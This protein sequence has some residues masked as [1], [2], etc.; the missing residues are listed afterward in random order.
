MDMERLKNL[1]KKTQERTDADPKEL[2]Q[3]SPERIASDMLFK[4]ALESICTTLMPRAE[5]L[6]EGTGRTTISCLISI[7]RKEIV[8][9]VTPGVGGHTTI[10]DNRERKW[11]VKIWF[12]DVTNGEGA[13]ELIAENDEEI[14]Y[15]LPAI[16]TAICEYA[17]DMHEEDGHDTSKL[18]EFS[19][20]AMAKR[21]GGMH[22]A[23]SKGGGE[24]TL[25][26]RYQ[27]DD[28]KY[29]ICQADISRA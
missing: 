5:I 24:A 21:M 16:G 23:I 7:L 20:V 27:L 25:R 17:Q 18:P 15:G 11:S 2:R 12:W 9:Y 1:G 10:S 6:A 8:K 14:M 22:P 4:D 28:G 19:A 3:D 13:R 29:Y 26:V